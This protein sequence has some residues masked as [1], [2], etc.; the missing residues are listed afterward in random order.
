[1]NDYT[2][3]E[4]VIYDGRRL[5]QTQEGNS[6]DDQKKRKNEIKHMKKYKEKEAH[7]LKDEFIREEELIKQNGEK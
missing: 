1:M 6:W 7:I 4:N 3:Y 2:T 5:Y